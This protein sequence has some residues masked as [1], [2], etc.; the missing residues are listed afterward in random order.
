MQFILSAVLRYLG[1]LVIARL[2]GK[3][4]MARLT[5]F[6]WVIGITIG[7]VVAGAVYSKDFPIW[8]WGLAAAATLGG[9]EIG[10]SYLALKSP[11]ARRLL[12]STPTVLVKDGRV[13]YQN[14]ARERFNLDDL[15]TALRAAHIDR[16]ADVRLA[17]LEPSGEVSVIAA[18][19]RPSGLREPR[20]GEQDPKVRK[21]LREVSEVDPPREPGR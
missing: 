17:V 4:E 3:R 8:P 20:E 12:E 19:R 21:A 5:F 16:I 13:L 1:L 7:S 2:M 18:G 9:L 11:W 10:T 14:L 6:D 15:L